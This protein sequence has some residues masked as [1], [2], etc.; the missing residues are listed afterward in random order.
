MSRI[1]RAGVT[2]DIAL[3]ALLAAGF[4]LVVF[5]ATGGTDLGPN[6]WVQIALLVI[7]AGCAVALLLAGPRG[8][9]EGAVALGLF[10]VL[11][12][13][14]YA[15]IAWSVQPATSWTEANRTLS[16]LAAFG[17]AA[18]LARLIP[19]RWPAL[20]GAVGTVAV[21]A[22]G[23][24]LLTKVFPA[25][26]D[27]ADTFGRLRTPFDYWNATGLMAAMGL[28]VCLW[29]GARPASGRLLRSLSVPAIAVLVTALMLSY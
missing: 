21:V 9:I 5:I 22:C 12:A 28:P 13:L 3:G 18:A 7:A 15:S 17:A 11:A 16:Y 20:T 26:L 29:A 6:T 14:T 23:Y 8:R 25:T 4:T 27:A 19:A 24:A 1:R 10:A 2:T